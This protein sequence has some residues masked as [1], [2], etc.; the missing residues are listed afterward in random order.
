M[1]TAHSLLD[2]T[3]KIICASSTGGHKGYD[4]RESEVKCEGRG[5]KEAFNSGKFAHFDHYGFVTY[6]KIIVS[7]K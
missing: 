4:D 2:E 5:S 1:Y 6:N 7:P 3:L